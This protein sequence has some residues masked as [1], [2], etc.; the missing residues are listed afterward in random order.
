[1]K[2]NNTHQVGEI[3]KKLMKNPKLSKRLDNLDA[4]EAWEKCIGKPLMKYIVD[5]KISKNILYVKL[6]SAAMR[7][8]LSYKKTQLITQVNE[9]LGK[10][11]I[12]DI[13]LK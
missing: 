11:I 3:I 6:S 8:E 12:S 7:N 5:Q 4:L 13:V 2:K 1:M 9:K 10:K